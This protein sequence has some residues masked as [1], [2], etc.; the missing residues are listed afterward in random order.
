MIDFSGQ[1]GSYQSDFDNPFM[2]IALGIAVLWLALLGLYIYQ[3]NRN[4]SFDVSR[5]TEAG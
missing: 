4:D 3:Q 5:K 1:Q 2:E